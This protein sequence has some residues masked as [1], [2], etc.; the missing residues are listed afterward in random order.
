MASAAAASA[1]VCT[2]CARS[3]ELWGP[4]LS[5]TC[6]A[7]L[8]WLPAHPAASVSDAA[9]TGI[10]RYAPLLPP[11]TKENRVTLG[12]AIT[13]TIEHHGVSLKL[14]FLLPTGSFKDRG[15]SVLVACARELRV[16]AAVAD[17]S[18]NA[19]AALAAYF[20]RAGIPLTVFVPGA[21]SSPKVRQAEHYGARVERVAGGRDAA[22]S[23]ARDYA[24]R[25]GAFY[26]SHAWSPFFLA[27]MRT[28][29]WEL[30]QELRGS[31]ATVVVPV[32]AGT[33]ALGLYE[34]FALLDQSPRLVGVQAERC[35]P[36]AHAFRGGDPAAVAWHPSVAAGICIPNPPRAREILDAFANSAGDIVTVTERE[37]EAAHTELASAGIYVEKTSAA[38][39]A[40]AAKVSKGAADNDVIVVL[41]GSGLKEGA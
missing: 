19:G 36:L 1:R 18:G 13:P 33:L 15:A 9:G 5:C 10:W 30:N 31:P 6:G 38:A 24:E 34:G 26:A 28:L 22:T 41:T 32:G 40:G 25:T 14:D 29:A 39:W 35:S 4:E 21:A 11:V 17:S 20:A 23:A 7:P 16:E 2:Q 8:R 37:I 3:Y 12:E 27:G